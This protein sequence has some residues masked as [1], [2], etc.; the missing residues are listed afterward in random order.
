MDT[1]LSRPLGLKAER[2]SMQRD[3]GGDS[4]PVALGLG[5]SLLFLL[6]CIKLRLGVKSYC[7]EEY[8]T[9]TSQGWIYKAI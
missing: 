9:K 1:D 3:G 7:P 4:L 2:Y 8:S 5:A 6:F